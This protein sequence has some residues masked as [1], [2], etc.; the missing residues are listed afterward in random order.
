M[1]SNAAP[2]MSLPRIT[3][4][5]SVSPAG[6]AAQLG[7]E[8]G[9]KPA[10]R[11]RSPAPNFDFDEK[12]RHLKAVDE[13]EPGQDVERMHHKTAMNEAMRPKPRD[14]ENVATPSG[15]SVSK[16]ADRY[17]WAEAKLYAN[18]K[19]GTKHGETE[20][21]RKLQESRTGT[22]TKA[23]GDRIESTAPTRL[24]DLLAGGAG[25]TGAWADPL[26]AEMGLLMKSGYKASKPA[27]ARESARLERVV[28]ANHA[29]FKSK[30]DKANAASQAR[31]A[32]ELESRR[33]KK[34]RVT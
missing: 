19:P 5:K 2:G 12:S 28:A 23:A 11:E 27:S 15:T 21:E 10:E 32:A 25:N 20:Q 13:W 26:L 24:T 30:M 4:M 31:I 9:F 18:K 16:S 17:L 8:P 6:Q 33:K 22:A 34:K 1:N 7:K 29:H 3:D 14:Q